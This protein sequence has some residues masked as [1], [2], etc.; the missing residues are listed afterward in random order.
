MRSRSLSFSFFL[1]LCLAI[2]AQKIDSIPKPIGRVNDFEGIF[3][4]EQSHVLDSMLISFEKKTTIQIAIITIDTSM[5]KKDELDA[6]T[7]KVLNS[8]G[9]GQK[10]QD[11]GILIG[12]SRGYRRMR[13]QNGYGIEKILTDKETKQIIDNDFIPF[14]KKAEYFEG[15]V[16]GLNALMKKLG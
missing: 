8:W 5:M 11:N 10:N 2:S 9:V 1:F 4:I 13:I 7:L 15:T 6:W 3:T 14:F 12:I 16:N